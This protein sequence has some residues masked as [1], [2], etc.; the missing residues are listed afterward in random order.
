MRV[1]VD[2]LSCEGNAKCMEAASE[3]FDWGKGD[4]ACVVIEHPPEELMEKVRLAI[5][6]CPKGAISIEPD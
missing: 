5:G 4:T 1:V 3:V 2:E 6:N